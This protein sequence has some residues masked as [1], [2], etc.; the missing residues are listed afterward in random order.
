MGHWLADVH[1]GSFAP[2]VNGVRSHFLE[3]IPDP[4]NSTPLIPADPI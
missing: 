3:M 4:I 1:S 2:E